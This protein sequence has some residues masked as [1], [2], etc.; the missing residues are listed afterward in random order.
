[1]TPIT[2]GAVYEFNW[3]INYA[4]HH[5]CMFRYGGIEKVNLSVRTWDCNSALKRKECSGSEI[6]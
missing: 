6:T 1:M 2:P 4:I 3:Y 5:A